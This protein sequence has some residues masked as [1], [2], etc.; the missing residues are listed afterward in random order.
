MAK[1]VL[2]PIAQTMRFSLHI[3]HVEDD[4][5]IAE[6]E[7]KDTN[8]QNINENMKA[9]ASPKRKHAKAARSRT[10]FGQ[11]EEQRQ[12]GNI[13]AEKKMW[14][15]WLGFCARSGKANHIRWRAKSSP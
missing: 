12:R 14:I 4:A 13:R 1:W 8:N 15:S 2:V 11:I 6:P 7:Q 9:S 10:Y 3:I 5:V